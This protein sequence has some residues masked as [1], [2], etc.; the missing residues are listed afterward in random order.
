MNKDEL[1]QWKERL[2]VAG[3]VWLRIRDD[4]KA[5]LT[6]A[7]AAIWP[8][9]IHDPR[10]AYKHDD[11]EFFQRPSPQ[12]IDDAMVIYEGIREVDKIEG[13]Q[14]GCVLSAFAI[15]L[16]WAGIQR[17]LEKIAKKKISRSTANRRLDVA[18]FYLDKALK[19]ID[20]VK[21]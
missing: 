19:N 16:P 4:H 6:K 18:I 15:G 21:K 2:R 17:K 1:K 13:E 10:D 20:N 9:V 7:E 8:E 14:S 11:V 12:E 5:C 3:D